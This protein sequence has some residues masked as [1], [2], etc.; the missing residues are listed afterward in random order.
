MDEAPHVVLD[1]DPGCEKQAAGHQYG[2]AGDAAAAELRAEGDEV[3]GEPA[4]DRRHAAAT[5]Q[6]DRGGS[7]QEDRE[8]RRGQ[9]DQGED[10]DL[11]DGRQRDER[12]RRVPE[13]AGRQG[14]PQAREHLGQPVGV[15]LL[16]G[17]QSSGD[18]LDGIIGRFADETDAEDKGDQVDLAEDEDHAGGPGE[19]AGGDADSP[20]EQHRERPKEEQHDQDD[21]EDRADADAVGVGPGRALRGFGVEDSAHAQDARGRM[22]SA[23]GLLGFVDRAHDFLLDGEIAWRA[24]RFGDDEYRGFAAVGAG[25]E[26]AVTPF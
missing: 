2:G 7:E 1:V 22:G 15:V 18:Q 3:G 19:D 14:H 8:E 5:Q 25:D 26:Q 24:L 13:Q 21:P 17:G 10:R 12:H 9:A 20:A 6:P 16:V 11:A 4:E 23:E